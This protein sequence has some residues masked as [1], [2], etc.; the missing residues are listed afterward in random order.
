MT[1]KVTMRFFFFF[2]HGVGLA[3]GEVAIQAFFLNFMFLLDRWAEKDKIN[4]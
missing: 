1:V 2:K 3:H 4:H